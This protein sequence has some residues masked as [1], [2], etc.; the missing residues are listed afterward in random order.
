MSKKNFRRKYEKMWADIDQYKL[1]NYTGQQ[2][3][4][5]FFFFAHELQ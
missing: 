2:N 4:T 5:F 3:F 1:N